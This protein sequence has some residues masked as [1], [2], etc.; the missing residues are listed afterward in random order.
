MPAGCIR[1]VCCS[2][3]NRARTAESARSELQEMPTFSGSMN[4]RTRRSALRF[5]LSN[6][7]RTPFLIKR[8]ARVEPV[9]VA[10]G[11]VQREEMAQAGLRPKLAG[12]FEAAL[13]LPARTLHRPLPIGSRRSMVLAYSPLAWRG[14]QNTRPQRRQRVGPAAAKSPV[15]PEGCS[16]HPADGET[17]FSAFFRGL[18]RGKFGA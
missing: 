4:T 15:P 18:A 5:D 17:V 14:T 1:R 12:P 8:V 6:T 10:T 2:N 3:G 11:F 13:L 9:M 16:L 7:P